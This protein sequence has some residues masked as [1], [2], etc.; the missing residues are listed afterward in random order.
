MNLLIKL[1]EP[2][3]ER[4]EDFNVKKLLESSYNE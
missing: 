1:N 3:N 2:I 4:N